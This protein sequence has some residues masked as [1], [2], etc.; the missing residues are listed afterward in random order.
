M[1]TNFTYFSTV[2]IHKEIH[3]NCKLY[4]QLFLSLFNFLFKLNFSFSKIFYYPIKTKQTQEISI[5]NNLANSLGTKSIRK[6]KH[7][8]FK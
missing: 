7:V 8:S 2:Y 3:S 1:Y 6:I 5:I 4:L